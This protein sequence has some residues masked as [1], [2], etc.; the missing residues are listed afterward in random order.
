MRPFDQ[1]NFYMN[2]VWAR[3]STFRVGKTQTAR[4]RG[5]VFHATAQRREGPD[6][7]NVFHGVLC[8]VA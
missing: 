7:V 1:L 2:Q 5:I 6:L 4:I 8:G 3:G